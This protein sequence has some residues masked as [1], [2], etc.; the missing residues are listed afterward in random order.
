MLVL[1][2]LYFMLCCGMFCFRTEN[3]DVKIV[4]RVRG[5]GECDLLNIF[6]YS[7]TSTEPGYIATSALLVQSAL[8]ITDHRDLMP[9]RY[10]IY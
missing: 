7:Y 1:L 8:C 9:K 2:K 5:V 4:T 3:P 6:T 10:V